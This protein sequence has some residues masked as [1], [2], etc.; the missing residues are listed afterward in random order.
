M[1]EDH[2]CAALA[3]SAGVANPLGYLRAIQAAL[4]VETFVFLLAFCL[5][6]NAVF[7]VF[8]VLT[9]PAGVS[10]PVVIAFFSYTATS[11]TKSSSDMTAISRS[12]GISARTSVMYGFSS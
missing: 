1:D 11:P 7:I 6:A 4:G 12:V 8:K 3:A 9:N 2:S 10:F 5:A